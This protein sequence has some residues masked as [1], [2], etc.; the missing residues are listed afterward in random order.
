MK[1]KTDY[2]FYSIIFS[3]LI[4]GAFLGML[5]KINAYVDEILTWFTQ[6]AYYGGLGSGA[7]ISLFVFSLMLNKLLL[8]LTYKYEVSTF[9]NVQN[10]PLLS[11]EQKN[12]LKKAV[13]F[14][15]NQCD[16]W[17]TTTSHSVDKL[18]NGQDI[19]VIDF[20]R[21]GE[22]TQIGNWENRY[23]TTEKNQAVFDELYKVMMPVKLKLENEVEYKKINQNLI[24][25]ADVLGRQLKIAHYSAV[26]AIASAL[27]SA[28]LAYITYLQVFSN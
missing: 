11:D 20:R 18:L 15:D 1:Q 8:H 28:F 22:A 2:L 6:A 9:G 3:V 21:I 26:A 19:N 25:D 24:K 13:Y 5:F 12:L 23:K 10:I 7:L 17:Y 16:G 4:F 27:A 14:W